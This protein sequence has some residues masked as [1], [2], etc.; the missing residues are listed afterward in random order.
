MLSERK[1][2][3]LLERYGIAPKTNPIKTEEDSPKGW[4]RGKGK[5]EKD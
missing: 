1:K 2:L 5:G 3:N 4:L